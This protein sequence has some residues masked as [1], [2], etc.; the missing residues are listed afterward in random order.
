[1]NIPVPTG[2]RRHHEVRIFHIADWRRVHTL[3]AEKLRPF[4]AR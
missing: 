3:F 4:I 2:W 1:M